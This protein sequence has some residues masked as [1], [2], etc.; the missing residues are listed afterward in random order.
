ED[1]NTIVVTV[2]YGT[3]STA[4]SPVVE[5]SQGASY[6]SEGAQDFT[7]PVTYT[8][9]AQNGT[10]ATYEVTVTV[11]PNTENEIVNFLFSQEDNEHLSQD[12]SASI[13]QEINTI[14][15][16]VQFGTDVT[17]LT[18]ALE[19]SLGATVEPEG[20]QDFT[21]PVTYTVTAQNGASAEY[22]VTVLVA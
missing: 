17:S 10:S 12:I 14:T 15:A 21:E 8:V 6:A 9:T 13:D 1:I 3:N 16:V 5:V 11:A 2:P 7:E 4:L 20:A 22:T 18:P 19:V